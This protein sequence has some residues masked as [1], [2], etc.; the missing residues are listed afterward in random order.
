MTRLGSSAQAFSETG[1]S[2]L[3]WDCILLLFELVPCE[4]AHARVGPHA[5]VVSPPRFPMTTGATFR[6]SPWFPATALP[7]PGAWTAQGEYVTQAS[8]IAS[9]MVPAGAPDGRPHSS[10]EVG[11]EPVDLLPVPGPDDEHVHPRVV[12]RMDE[13]PVAKADT[14]EPRTRPAELLAAGGAGI[15]REPPDRREKRQ[16]ATSGGGGEREG[17]SLERIS[18]GTLARPSTTPRFGRQAHLGELNLPAELAEQ[19][20]VSA[21]ELGTRGTR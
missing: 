15:G 11:P 14:T 13:A 7:S 6:S 8:T 4:V 16:L 19:I 5:A 2:R 9:P 3:V 20:S 1:L 10:Q 21:Q 18:P 17:W 12:D